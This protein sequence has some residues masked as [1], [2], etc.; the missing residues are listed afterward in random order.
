MKCYSAAGEFYGC[1]YAALEF[2]D[3]TMRQHGGAFFYQWTYKAGGKE[4]GYQFAISDIE[5]LYS[6]ALPE[7]AKQVAREWKSKEVEG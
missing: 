2:G 7:L 3:L 5:L 1:L 6:R 4:Y